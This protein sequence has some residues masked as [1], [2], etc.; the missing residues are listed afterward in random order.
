MLGRTTALLAA[1]LLSG[2]ASDY[3]ATVAL[4]RHGYQL[5]ELNLLERDVIEAAASRSDRVGLG[6][7]NGAVTVTAWNVTK[8]G[9]AIDKVKSFAREHQKSIDTA[10]AEAFWVRLSANG[11]ATP[12]VD[13]L[14]GRFE[15]YIESLRPPLPGVTVKSD[16]DTAIVEANDPDLGTALVK[17]LN[18]IFVTIQLTSASWRVSW[19]TQLLSQAYSAEKQ[20]DLVSKTADYVRFVLR[21]PLELQ[22][23]EG[24]DPDNIEIKGAH[25]LVRD[26]TQHEAFIESVRKTFDKNPLFIFSEVNAAEARIIGSKSAQQSSEG[27]NVE[28]M[29][30]VQDVLSPP[31]KVRI[32]GDGIIV[33]AQDRTRNGELASI[34]RDAL[35]QRKNLA[36]K[37][38]P[39]GGL[40]VE[41]VGNAQLD[42]ALPK[43]SA[44][45]FLKSVTA[46][47][48]GTGVHPKRVVPIDSERV[49]VTFATPPDEDKL[50]VALSRT[51]GLTFRMVDEQ[52]KGATN[53]AP[54]DGDTRLKLPTG[55]DIWVQPQPIITGDMVADVTV[56]ENKVT[57][58][59]VIQFRLTDEGREQF[60]AATRLHIGKRFAIIVND[61]AVSAP[62]ILSP[63]LGG[64]G[65]ING[66]F[67]ADSANDLVKEILP[68]R[69]DLLLTME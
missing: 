48:E 14:E 38:L 16:G 57:K 44:N 61:T 5:R 11:M 34:V 51:S 30:A 6:M 28:F 15:G 26:P 32:E 22:V 65:E 12:S 7:D 56:G 66:N 23:Y 45:D 40:R 24:G 31:N 19:N 52:S 3:S 20:K 58:Q 8:D 36:I 35:A 63:I 47:F 25:F 50:R 62:V 60:A 21:D 9:G 49:R 33:E 4:D 27:A 2:C 39:E 59:P 54:L 17:P 37:P 55:E 67:T 29:E 42:R 64:A 10:P 68:H 41:L 53:A 18:R 69:D 43:L 46:R 1:I 13:R